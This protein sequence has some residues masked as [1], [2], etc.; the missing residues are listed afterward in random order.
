MQMRND[1]PIGCSVLEQKFTLVGLNQ[2][3]LYM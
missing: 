2:S 1:Y 3:S